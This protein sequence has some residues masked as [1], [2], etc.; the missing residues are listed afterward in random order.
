M[1]SLYECSQVSVDAAIAPL[2]LSRSEKANNLARSVL[3]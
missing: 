2:Q 1:G 3:E